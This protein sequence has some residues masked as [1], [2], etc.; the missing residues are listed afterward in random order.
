MAEAERTR[1]PGPGRQGRAVHRRT[2][3]AGSPG[4]R[5]RSSIPTFDKNSV[6][7]AG[8]PR[9]HW[10]TLM[11]RVFDGRFS[12]LH[13]FVIAQNVSFVCTKRSGVL[14]NEAHNPA[15]IFVCSFPRFTLSKLFSRSRSVQL[16]PQCPQIGPSVQDLD[17]S[18]VH[19]IKSVLL[20]DFDPL[21]S[22][23]TAILAP[24]GIYLKSRLL[25]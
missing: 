23:L 25:S 8:N 6:V 21:K 9:L 16:N 2:T 24:I 20:S 19:T 7:N 15:R 5:L 14:N 17:D 10:P 22:A 13:K 3:K 1:P 4:Y 11:I 18:R 12:L